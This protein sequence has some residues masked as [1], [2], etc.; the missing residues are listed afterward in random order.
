MVNGNDLKFL[1]KIDHI[2]IKYLTITL[3]KPCHNDLVTTTKTKKIS[4]KYSNVVVYNLHQ[5]HD[6][7]QG[8][9]S[10]LTHLIE[11]ENEALQSL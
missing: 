1:K 7:K 4:I 6:L 8:S 3:K 9:S 10:Q 2:I 11:Y 5:N